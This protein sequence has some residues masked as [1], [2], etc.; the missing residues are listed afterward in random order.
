MP[1][2]GPGGSGRVRPSSRQRRCAKAGPRQG[3]E[4]GGSAAPGHVDAWKS[5]RDDLCLPGQLE[6][7]PDVGDEGD[8]W[9]AVS[10]DRL[11]VRIVLALREGYNWIDNDVMSFEMGR[12]APNA[13]E[14]RTSGAWHGGHG[15]CRIIS[16][17][18]SWRPRSSPPHPE[19]RL[20]TLMGGAGLTAAEKGRSRGRKGAAV[21]LV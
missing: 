19:K 13:L 10:Q 14:G 17:P 6:E 11:R 5:R 20:T 4:G 3:S 8:S 12:I 1:F 7:V 16:C 21:E 9:E 2:L 18:A 15:T